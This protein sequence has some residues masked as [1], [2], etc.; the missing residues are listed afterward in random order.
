MYF[1][2]LC[3]PSLLHEMEWQVNR[4]LD[5]KLLMWLPACPMK[6]QTVR[7]DVYIPVRGRLLLGALNGRRWHQMV[8]HPAPRTYRLNCVIAIMVVP[9][10]PTNH[11]I[12]TMCMNYILHFFSVP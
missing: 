8:Y 11:A 7:I 10:K 1:H 12:R 2:Q 3:D 5:L 9:G 6:P 4:P